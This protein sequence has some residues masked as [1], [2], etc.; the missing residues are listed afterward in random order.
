MPETP[1]PSP[2]GNPVG[3]LPPFCTTPG[4]PVGWACL[5]GVHE[6]AGGQWLGVSFGGH[7]AWQV[8]MDMD[9]E[10]SGGQRAQQE[11]VVAGEARGPCLQLCAC[12]GLCTVWGTR[13]CPGHFRKRGRG[14]LTDTLTRRLEQ[15][16]RNGALQLWWDLEHTEP[17]SWPV[18]RRLQKDSWAVGDADPG[19]AR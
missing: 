13:W 8:T 17:W 11:V 1:G 6:C 9:P 4:F 3:A 19:T 16:T 14:H 2:G 15:K 10:H 12:P 5:P 18:G 7:G